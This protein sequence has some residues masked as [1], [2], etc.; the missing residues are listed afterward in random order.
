MAHVHAISGYTVNDLRDD[1]NRRFFPHAAKQPAYV[2]WT[3]KDTIFCKIAS[4]IR[5]D[6]VTW[7]GANDIIKRFNQQLQLTLMFQLQE[8]LYECGARNFIFFTVPPFDRTPWGAYSPLLIR[9]IPGRT[10]DPIYDRIIQWN[11]ELTSLTNTFRNTH[12]DARV[13]LFSTGVSWEKMLENPKNYGFTD[14]ISACASREC[15][16]NTDVTPPIHPTFAVHNVLAEDLARF[17]ETY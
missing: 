17:L 14:D 2:P 3:H 16:W 11:A 5:A 8:K 10:K 7:I 13:G 1:L 6:Q 9:L 12:K 4:K 15:M